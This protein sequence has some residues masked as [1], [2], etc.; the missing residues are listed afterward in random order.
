MHGLKERELENIMTNICEAEWIKIVF[1]IIQNSGGAGKSN[2]SKSVIV[3]VPVLNWLPLIPF[4]I[5][6]L[7]CVFYFTSRNQLFTNYKNDI[8]RD[9]A[10]FL[11]LLFLVSTVTDETSELTRKCEQNNYTKKKSK[12]TVLF[13]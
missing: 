2:S 7:R 4:R 6:I 13:I 3:F 1:R 5:Y 12:L 8:I 9:Y 10:N 11:P